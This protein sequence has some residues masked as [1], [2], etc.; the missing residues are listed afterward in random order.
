MKRVFQCG[1]PNPYSGALVDELIEVH[2]GGGRDKLFKVYYGLQCKSGLSY[3]Q[4]CKEIGA[5]ILH[6]ACCE[7]QA[8]N[9]GK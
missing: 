4:A 7:G 3:E 2:Q 1:G 6:N 5:A 9:E 8:S